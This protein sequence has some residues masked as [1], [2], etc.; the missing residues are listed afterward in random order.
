MTGVS[1]TSWSSVKEFDVEG[2]VYYT[3]KLVPRL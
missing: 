2:V 1:I 3:L